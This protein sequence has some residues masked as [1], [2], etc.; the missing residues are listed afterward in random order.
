[1]KLPKVTNAIVALIMANFM[2]LIGVLMLGW[3]AAVIVLLYWAENIVIGLY[4]V[5]K[6]IF[7]KIYSDAPILEVL[8]A[9][10]FFCFH[11]GAFCAVHGYLLLVLFHGGG[12]SGTFIHAGAWTESAGSMQRLLRAF[13]GFWQTRPDGMVWSVACLFLSHGV[14]IK[15]NYLDKKEYQ[16]FNPIKLMIQPYK[17][18]VILHL[19][20]ISGAMLVTM[21][22]SPLPLLCLL[23][24]FKTGMDIVLH[25]K[26]HQTQISSLQLKHR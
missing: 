26:E 9:I 5:L 20:V 22:G 14:S 3:D 24:I 25:I 13:A 21:S 7:L 2:P 19:A 4:N 11:F 18:I 10:S 17:R 16:L 15:R 12:P 1:M 23:I 8:F 6:I